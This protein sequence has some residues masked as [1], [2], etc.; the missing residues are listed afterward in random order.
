MTTETAVDAEKQ[1]GEQTRSWRSEKEL[2]ERAGPCPGCG[3]ALSPALIDEELAAACGRVIEHYG[4]L[5]GEGGYWCGSCLQKSM[6]ERRRAK[7]RRDDEARRRR[8]NH[9]GLWDYDVQACT[10]AASA[11][12]IERRT[13]SNRREVFSELREWSPTRANVWLWSRRP[14]VGKTYLAAALC[15]A[16]LEQGV[17][18]ALLSGSRLV[19]LAK[20]YDSG[21]KLAVFADADLLLLD[22]LDKALY[23]DVVEAALFTVLDGRHRGKKATI[24]TANNTRRDLFLAWRKR[25][26]VSATAGAALDRLAWPGHPLWERE[27]TGQSVRSMDQMELM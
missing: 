25:S 11:Q 20:G 8:L 13:G 15:N 24:V 16:E 9:E 14:G 19:D 26:G 21:D 12:V 2:A 23:S 6:D 7:E 18:P 5:I 27:I 4:R 10:F 22:D 17:E 3:R 1:G